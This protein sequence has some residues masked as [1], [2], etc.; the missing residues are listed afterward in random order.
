MYYRVDGGPQDFIVA[1]SDGDALELA[2]WFKLCAPND[3]CNN[4]SFMS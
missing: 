3:S 4:L 2:R 1:R